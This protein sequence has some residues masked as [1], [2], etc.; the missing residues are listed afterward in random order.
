VGY[1][2][3]GIRNIALVG[4]SA[5]GKTTLFEALLHAG[6]A[7]QTPGTIERGTTVSDHDPL[8]KQRQHSLNAS[9]ASIDS[10]DC[11]INLLDTPGS[12]DFRG[13]TLTALAAV[14][15]CAIVVNAHAGIEYGT[16]RMMHHAKQRG[17]ARV[18]VVRAPGQTRLPVAGGSVFRCRFQNILLR[19]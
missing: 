14:E 15:T 7:I 4:H 11:H 5:A 6:G 2:T 16:Q 18:I 3:E 9:I 19:S 12:Q 17:L 10:G 13:P 1:T 8:E